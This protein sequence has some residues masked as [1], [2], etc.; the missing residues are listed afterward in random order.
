[1]PLMPDELCRNDSK[2]EST[3]SLLQQIESLTQITSKN[4]GDC[5]KVQTLVSQLNDEI[6]ASE[7]SYKSQ[8]KD[9]KRAQDSSFADLFYD[10]NE[11]IKKLQSEIEELKSSLRVAKAPAFSEAVQMARDEMEHYGKKLR[12]KNDDIKKLMN[13]LAEAKAC[14]DSLEKEKSSTKLVN[15][16]VDSIKEHFKIIRK[17]LQSNKKMVQMM[18]TEKH[19]SDSKI[20]KEFE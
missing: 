18:Q 4:E 2:F 7:R 3:Q 17:A 15:P 14:I 12:Q 19:S 8:I 9:M 1:M 20:A 13:K 5:K 10:K 11:E 16:C 6:I